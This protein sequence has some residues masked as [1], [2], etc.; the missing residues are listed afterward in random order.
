MIYEIK[1]VY[2]EANEKYDSF[3]DDEWTGKWYTLKECLKGVQEQITRR[4]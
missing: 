2:C 1:I 3:I 4:E